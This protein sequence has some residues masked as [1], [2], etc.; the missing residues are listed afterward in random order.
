[1]KKWTRFAARSAD[2]THGSSDSVQGKSGDE[3]HVFSHGHEHA[4][5]LMGLTPRQRRA[6][7]RKARRLSGNVEAYAH[8]LAMKPREGYLFRSDYFKIDDGFACVLG[9]FH[10]DAAQDDFGAFW[11]IGRIPMGLGEGVSTVMLEQVRRMS[12]K[13]INDH[14]KSTEALGKLAERE[15]KGSGSTATSRRRL[16]KSRQDT[17]NIAAELLDGAS[18]LHVHNRILLKAPTLA[19]LDTSVDRIKRL[20]V[21]RFATLNVAPYHGEQR[22]E[23][24]TLLGRNEAKRGKGFH[25]TS[26]EFAGS[27]S[28]VTNGLND[29]AGEYVGHM[30]GDVNNSAVIFDVDQWS[31]HTVVA[32]NAMNT[33][34][35]F[36]RV[37]EADLWGSKISQAALLNNHKVVHLVLDGAD[38]N[39]LGPRLDRLTARLDMNS[40]DVNFLELFGEQKDEL[41]IF[42]AHLDKVVLMAEQAHETTENER[43][44]VR[45]SLRETLIQFYVDKQMW[46]HNAKE[47]RERLRLVGLPHTQVPRLQDLVTY[48]DTQYKA[49]ANSSARDNELLHAY[50]TLRIVFNDMLDTNG[51]LFNSFTN[52]Q[53][54][55]VGS[56]RRVIYDF[57]DLMLRGKGIAMAQ[58]VNIVGFAIGSLGAGDVLVI[59]GAELIDERVKDYIST[60]FEHLFRRGGRVAYL[61]TSI[62]KMIADQPFNRFDTA[63]WTVLGNMSDGTVEAYQKQLHQE[64]PRDLEKL[65][66]TTSARSVY[67]RHG[68]VNVVFQAD[69][70]LGVNPARQSRRDEL[71]RLM[72][73]YKKRTGRQFSTTKSG[74]RQAV[75][76]R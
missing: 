34:P 26:T 71:K 46:Y 5:P 10:N 74:R 57:S 62:E 60:Q 19:S 50:S 29:P 2:G 58:L 59:H 21:E 23:V 68:H 8:L 73:G 52:S 25:Y 76:A 33:L 16:S 54:D 12:E 70:A 32:N 39:K 56:A 37:P 42:P 1:M 40:G 55:D 36:G 24:S 41:S 67:L 28:L 53:I 51:D 38:L 61:Y 7:Q 69:L 75:A 49:L 15:Q 9:Y 18:Y 45:G 13:W 11:G 44:V 3:D 35:L 65:I 6:A 4:D 48:F 31:H 47:N 72:S 66:T 64:I 30:L 14:L 22:R 17:E 63:D 43:S 20:Y 27:H